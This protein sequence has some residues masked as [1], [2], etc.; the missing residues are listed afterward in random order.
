VTVC[1]PG[2]GPSPAALEAGSPID[3][4]DPSHRWMDR[5]VSS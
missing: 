5:P 1:W 4:M 2:G 3:T